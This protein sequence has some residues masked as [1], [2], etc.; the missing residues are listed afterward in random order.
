[1]GNRYVS[2]DIIDIDEIHPLQGVASK[3]GWGYI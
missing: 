3:K 1:M 2:P